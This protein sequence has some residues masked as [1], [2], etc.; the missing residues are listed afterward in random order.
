MPMHNTAHSYGSVAKFLHWS[1]VILVIVQFY[2]AES[3]DDLPDGAEKFQIIAR[4]K[5]LGVL[6]LVLAIA[7]IL[8]K[9]AMRGRPQ[10]VGAGALKKAAAA[11]H[12]LLYLLLLAQPI[13]G[14]AMA[15]A[16]GAKVTFFGWFT[17]PPL[18][19][20]DHALHERLEDLHGALFWVLVAVAALHV[21]AALYHHFVLKDGVL[22]RMSPFDASID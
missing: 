8:W 12:G 19:H 21:A 17:L 20:A 4:H 22:R 15:S 6:L 3:A 16:A 18:A 10:P 2:L 11:G 13:S 1:I 9:L 14:W 5:T 7:R